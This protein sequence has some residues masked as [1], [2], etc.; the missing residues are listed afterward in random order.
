MNKLIELKDVAIGYHDNL[1]A[2]HLNFSLDGQTIVCL[3]GS[4]G[5]GKTTLLKT[6]LAILPVRSG[7]IYIEKKTQ[8]LWSKRSLAQFMAYVPQSH[9]YIFPFNVQEMVLMGRSMHLNWFKTPNKIDISIAHDC[10]EQVGISHLINKAY[11]RLSGGERQLVLIARALAQKPKF[12]IMDEPTASLDYGNQM[13]ILELIKTFRH[14]G[15]T[16][17]ITMHQPEHAFDI[18]DRIILFHQ[19]NILADDAPKKCLTIDNLSQIYSLDK[20]IISKNLRFVNND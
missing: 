1:V 14:R 6:I 3:L 5:C 12:L 7:Q 20:A 15:L 11:N 18:A 13:R 4:N 16:V 8:T 19:G 10:I 2:K 9:N 17:F